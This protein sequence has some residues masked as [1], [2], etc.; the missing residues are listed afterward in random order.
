M[1]ETIERYVTYFN[2]TKTILAQQYKN[3]KLEAST[4]GKI[5]KSQSVIKELGKELKQINISINKQENLV[6]TL[7]KTSALTETLHKIHY[8]IGYNFY[9]SHFLKEYNK[10]L[11]NKKLA[12]TNS[13]LYSYVIGIEKKLEEIQK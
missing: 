13:E 1:I 10:L 4:I 9:I 7:V 11:N 5:K 12:Q 8:Q 2:T 6:D 3:K